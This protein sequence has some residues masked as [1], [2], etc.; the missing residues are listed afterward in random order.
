MDD[1]L[2]GKDDELYADAVAIV[3]AT[4]VPSIS[5]LQR[6]L[7]IGFSRAAMLVDAMEHAGIVTS[8][9]NGKARE[10]VR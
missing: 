6:R 5:L 9:T 8:A 2:S 3:R 4:G 10:V 1:T 7:R